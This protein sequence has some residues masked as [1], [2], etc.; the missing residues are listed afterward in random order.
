MNRLRLL[1]TSTRLASRPLLTRHEQAICSSNYLTYRQPRRSKCEYRKKESISDQNNLFEFDEKE[2]I[3]ASVRDR[4]FQDLSVEMYEELYKDDQTGEVRANI[5]TIL[6]EY[7]YMKYN[8]D[9]RVPSNISVDQMA[10]FL[11]HGR[12]SQN[13]EK[14]FNYFFK[15][16]MR[17][18]S[19]AKLTKIK[20]KLAIDSLEEKRKLLTSKLG[21]HERTGPLSEEGRLIYGLWHNTLFTRIEEKRIRFDRSRNRLIEAAISGRKLIFDFD[22]DDLMSQGNMRSNVEQVQD[23]YGRNRFDY[24]DVRFDL[25]FCNLKPDSTSA[26]YMKSS[27]LKNV[28]DINSLVTVT[29]DCFTNYFDRSKLVYLTPNSNIM[30]EDVA[31]SDDIYII[32]ALNDKGATKPVT[33]SKAQRLGIRTRCLPLDKYLAWKGPTKSICVNHVAHLLLE[34]I[35]N[36]D[37]WKE[38]LHKSIPTRMIKP[39]ELIL[40]EEH[41]RK[42]RRQMKQGGFNL[43]D[44]LSLN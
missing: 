4:T 29:E 6:E 1:K 40:E 43:R 27:G 35:N 33:L 19:D 21:K 13:R 10:T 25:W 23:F 42:V 2:M 17:K 16:E 12:S 14:L 20:R 30:L 31:N 38:A 32:G 5:E 18:L 44:I 24:N 37:N 26:K 3:E 7:E 15:R 22:F 39:V 34:L 9:G 28:Y 36:G 11:E 41:K 8:N